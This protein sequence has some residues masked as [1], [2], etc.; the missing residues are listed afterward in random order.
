MKIY[1]KT[2]DD[3]TTGLFSAGRVRKDA[4]RIRAYGDVDELNSIL[5]VVMALDSG[6]IFKTR[7]VAIQ[8]LLF[9]AGADLATPLS[10]K[11]SYDVPRVTAEDIRALEMLIDEYE[12]SLEPLTQFILPGGSPLAAELHVARTVARRAE[13]EVVTLMHT[14]DIGAFILPFVNRLSD[15]FFVLARY[16]NQQLGV[17]EHAWDG[18]RPPNAQL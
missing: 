18:K 13:R 9:V 7:L 17:Q 6:G 14:E 12:E 5:G 10:A 8:R 3:G 1:T 11:V 2:G 16:A 15:L 4:A